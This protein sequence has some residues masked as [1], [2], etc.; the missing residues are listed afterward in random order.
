MKKI[1]LICFMALIATSAQGAIIGTTGDVDDTQLI[2]VSLVTG[3][4]ESDASIFIFAEQQAFALTGDLTLDIDASG[5]YQ[6][7]TDLTGG[8]IPSGTKVN[9]YIMHF[10]K[11]GGAGDLS[12]AGSVTFDRDVLGIIILTENLDNSDD[13]V[14]DAGTQYESDSPD[15][16]WHDFREPELNGQD[17]I[18]LSGDK[19]TVTVAWFT[20]QAID[21]IRIIEQA[22]SATA[23][24]EKTVDIN[25]ANL[26]DHITVTL[27]VD[28]PYNEP[29]EVKDVLPSDLKYIP[30]T[31]E[32][33]GAPATPTISGSS[34]STMVGPGPNTIEFQAQVTE[35]QAEDINVT[36]YAFICDPDGGL[37]DTDSV[38]IKLRAY[39][40]FSKQIVLYRNTD[41][42]LDDD[43]YNVPVE[44]DVHWLLLI[45]VDNVDTD[46]VDTM[47]DIVVTDRLGGDLEVHLGADG[48]VF[49]NPPPSTGALSTKTKGK[50]AKV[51]L[52]WK[53]LADLSDGALAQAWIEIST[54]TNPGKGKKAPH[55]EYTEEGDHYLNSGAVIKFIDDESAGGTGFQLSAH[56][57]ELMVTAFVP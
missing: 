36:N 24:A 45:K 40:G 16:Q 15:P 37:D 43:P 48:K 18:D 17:T 56:T 34:I 6:L 8:T 33:D 49:I 5:L 21:E 4:Y 46:M 47:A 25:D 12:L 9:S 1:M 10:D 2:P 19:R 13:A 52:T 28:N 38:E 26:G 41:D 27:T 54:D 53:N 39:E 50:T 57:G 22:P 35:V 11:V 20:A 31:F 14:G 42:P 3:A 23:T 30:Y 44:T 55:Q 51:F 29:I 7:E 32:V